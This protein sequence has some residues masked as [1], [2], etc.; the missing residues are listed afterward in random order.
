MTI[1]IRCGSA[2]A[3]SPNCS[4]KRI[5][6]LFC[7]IAAASLAPCKPPASKA[8]GS[9]PNAVSA[10]RKASRAGPATA[11]Q[12]SSGAHGGGAAG[13]SVEA[14]FFPSAATPGSR[15]SVC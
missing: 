8:A 2:R 1:T 6:K 4:A 15:S 5:R 12:A 7:S 3:T 11:S 9:A 10:L 14:G 13:V